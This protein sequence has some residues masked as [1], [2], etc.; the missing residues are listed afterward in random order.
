MNTVF[1]NTGFMHMLFA[2][3]GCVGKALMDSF[4]GHERLLRQYRLL[5]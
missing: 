3:M 1:M 2:H 4:V 5:A